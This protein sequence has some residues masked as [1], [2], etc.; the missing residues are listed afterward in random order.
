MLMAGDHIN[1][2]LLHEAS[3]SLYALGR[4]VMP[5]FG[6]VLVAHLARLEAFRNGLH[7]RVMKRLAV[8]ALLATPAFVQLVGWW[9]LNSLATLVLTTLIVW[10]LEQGGRRMRCRGRQA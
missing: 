2:Y 10:L 1:K 8:F 6:F 9:P 5:L 4:L 7:L 3:G